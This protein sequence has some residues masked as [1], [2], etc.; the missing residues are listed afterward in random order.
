MQQ[1]GKCNTLTASSVLDCTMWHSYC[2]ECHRY[3]KH[4]Q[5]YLE[6]ADCRLMLG[7]GNPYHRHA[8]APA[9]VY[10]TY[11]ICWWCVFTQR[12]GR[13]GGPNFVP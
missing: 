6:C 8:C 9:N 11:I 5:L 3:R 10:R 4:C 13:F 2:A 1:K 12:V 7:D